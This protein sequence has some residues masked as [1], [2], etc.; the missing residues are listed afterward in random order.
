MK[1]KSNLFFNF[2]KKEFG[3]M[4]S[5][6]QI[7]ELMFVIRKKLNNLKISKSFN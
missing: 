1:G 2:A 6:A 7:P 4:H 3:Y 5:Y